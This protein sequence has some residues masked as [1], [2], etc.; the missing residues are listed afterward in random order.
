VGVASAPDPIGLSGELQV[1]G[2]DRIFEG[3]LAPAAALAEAGSD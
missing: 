1:F 2:R 3:A